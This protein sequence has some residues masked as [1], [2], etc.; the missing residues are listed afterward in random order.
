MRFD[1]AQ[2]SR[3]VFFGL[4]GIIAIVVGYVAFS[5]VKY[6]NIADAKLEK[7]PFPNSSTLF[8]A[9]RTVGVGDD[10]TKAGI[11]AKLNESGY[12][13]DAKTNSYG[14]YH[15]TPDGIEIFPGKQSETE[16]EPAVLRIKDG[17]ILSIIALSDNSTR[18]EYA[19][20]P[21]V[22]STMFDENRAK[23]RLVKFEDIPPVM[24]NA[25]VS[26]E[27][28][29]FF[30]HSGFD[31]LRIVKAVFMDLRQGRKA[32]GASTLTQQLAKMIWLDPRKTF[33]RKFE[34]LLITVHLER[35]L[36]KQKIFEYYA[37]Q[38]PLGRRG[39]F[40]ISG[41]G[42]AAQAFFGKDMKQLNLPEAATLAGLIQQPSALNPFR[43]PDRAKARRNVVLKLMLDNGY[44]SRMEYTQA[45]E[46]PMNVTKQGIE[47]TDAPYF[48]DH[49]NEQLADQFGER[50]FQQSGSRIY[51]TL[52]LDLQH[53]AAMAVADGVKHLDEIL[54]KRNK[55]QPFEAPQVALI[56]LDPHTGEVKALI[57]GR[58][59]GMSQ[60]DHTNAERPSGSIFKPFVY[61]TALNGG[62][63]NSPNMMTTSSIVDDDPKTFLWNGDEYNP[64]D[65]HKNWLGPVTLRTAFAHSLNVPAIEVAEQAG[66]RNVADL[67]HKAGLENVRATPSMALGTYNVTAMDM[68]GAYTIFA[69]DGVMVSPRLIS[70]IVDKSG[71]DIW[72]SEAETKRVLD[73]RVNFLVVSLMQEVLRS[74]TAAGASRYGFNLP[75]AAKTGTSQDAWFAGFTSKLLCIVW[76][77][78]D[79][80]KDI[81]MQG[82]D[83]AMP[84]WAE[85]M[86]HAHEHRAYRNVSQFSIPSGIV[87]AQIDNGSGQLATGGCPPTDLRTEYY[88]DG[89]APTQYCPLHSGGTEVTGWQ[90]PLPNVPA[91]GLPPTAQVVPPTTTLDPPQAPQTDTNSQKDK[92]KKGLFE[93]LKKLFH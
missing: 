77:G 35:K 44:I 63:L 55:G 49:V 28:K 83:A 20:E 7:G 24:V 23:R 40:G 42:E 48:V 51:T 9:P 89:T 53:D 91:T 46:S 57:G 32:Y 88:L 75:A 70:H 34:E 10:A 37:N 38:V 71:K 84:I 76:V 21:A 90:E 16:S 66:Y 31:P 62:L 59:Y 13:E 43:W 25:V 64:H 39:S 78:L 12:E 4:L 36:T 74:G 80:Y 14:W 33:A 52:D 29:R 8:A 45:A 18:P 86:K 27:D 5:Y 6:S 50:D 61:A 15:L 69:N 41:F 73:P 3:F 87:S 60:L 79:D 85:F 26:I 67:A 92:P 17:K 54:T 81:K 19:L 93:K 2:I 30:Q 56:C 58:N 22:L 47:S 1:A 11:A 82:A 68:A 65:M 72:T